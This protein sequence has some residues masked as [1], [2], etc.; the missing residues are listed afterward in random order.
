M[1]APY[2]ALLVLQIVRVSVFRARSETGNWI[3]NLSHY[4]DGAFTVY[5]S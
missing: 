4:A 3:D 5:S 2:L 1:L